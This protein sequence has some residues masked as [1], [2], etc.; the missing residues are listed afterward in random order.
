MANGNGNGGRRLDWLHV[1][2]GL[3]TAGLMVLTISSGMLKERVSVDGENEFREMVKRRLTELEL[4]DAHVV[5]LFDKHRD[6]DRKDMEDVLKQLT[7]IDSRL[8]GLESYVR[9]RQR[10]AAALRPIAPGLHDALQRKFQRDD[11]QYRR[12]E[13]SERPRLSSLEER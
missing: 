5:D 9:E 10:R 11:L 6:I 1:L 4:S 2:L 13:M 3:F 12:Q 8:T 7:G